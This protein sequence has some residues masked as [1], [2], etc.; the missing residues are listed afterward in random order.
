MYLQISSVQ[1]LV[2][3]VVTKSIRLSATV[4]RICIFGTCM[5]VSLLG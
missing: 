2:R 4:G 1:S 3:A 5:Y